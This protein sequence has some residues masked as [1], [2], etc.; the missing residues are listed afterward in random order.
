MI[1]VHG[2]AKYVPWNA[3]ETYPVDIGQLSQSCFYL[4]VI[5]NIHIAYTGDAFK[6]FMEDRDYEKLWLVFKT[7]CTSV[8]IMKMYI[9]H[10][11]VSK[12]VYTQIEIIFQLLCLS[13]NLEQNLPI[14]LP[15]GLFLEPSVNI[16]ETPAW[17]KALNEGFAHYS[18]HLCKKVTHLLYLYIIL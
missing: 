9:R 15:F 16:L 13:M 7:F 14:L 6:K 10:A 17:I 5:F 1:L 18:C 3:I 12:T 8:Y 11:W 2:N 4:Q